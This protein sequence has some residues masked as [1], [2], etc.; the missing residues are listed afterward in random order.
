MDLSLRPTRGPSP[1]STFS[2][3]A[4]QPSRSLS[5]SAGESAGTTSPPWQMRPRPFSMQLP[6]LRE[7]SHETSDDANHQHDPT[8]AVNLTSKGLDYL[9]HLSRG[10]PTIKPAVADEDGADGLYKGQCHSP[11]VGN[12]TLDMI[13]GPE[14]STHEQAGPVSSCSSNYSATPSLED[15]KLEAP[16]VEPSPSPYDI[17]SLH[18]SDLEKYSRA[19]NCLSNLRSIS[20]S[21]GG[22]SVRDAAEEASMEAEGRQSVLRSSRGRQSV[23]AAR[24]QEFRL[25]SGFKDDTSTCNTQYGKYDKPNS[26]GTFQRPQLARRWSMSRVSPHPNSNT[27]D[28]HLPVVSQCDGTYDSNQQNDSGVT[29]TTAKR[30]NASLGDTE[31][32]IPNAATKRRASHFSLRS[33]SNSFATKRRRLSVRKFATAIHRQSVDMSRRLRRRTTADRRCFEA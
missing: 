21:S 20:D 1:S 16:T 11:G 10:N 24:Y 8:D 9:P 23:S 32:H 19:N 17:N 27:H 18:L 14:N 28:H 31:Q 33:L 6:S 30:R 25:N 15:D 5:S 7:R 2:R 29:N 12:L 13:P 26:P 3:G 22:E 4:P